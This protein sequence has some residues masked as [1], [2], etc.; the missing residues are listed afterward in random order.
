[1]KYRWS[2]FKHYEKQNELIYKKKLAKKN[3]SIFHVLC[4]NIQ[5]IQY[6]FLQLELKQKN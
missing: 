2:Y 6:K 3:Y 5:I 1:M 4:K